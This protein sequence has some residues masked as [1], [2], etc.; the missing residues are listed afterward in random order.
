MLETGSAV[1][2]IYKFGLL[3]LAL[4]AVL[5]WIAVFSLRPQNFLRVNVLDV[6]QGDAIL[7]TTISGSQVLIDGGPAGGGVLR[8]LSGQMPFFDRSLDLVVA[9]HADADHI[10]GLV[11]VLARYRVKYVLTSDIPADTATFQAFSEK[12][13]ASGAHI[14]RP[15]PGMKIWLDNST[16]LEILGPPGNFVP[17]ESNETSIVTRLRYGRTAVML[18]GDAPVAEEAAMIVS[19]R[20]LGAD[21]LKVGHHGSKTSTSNEFLSAVAPGFV[22]ISVGVKN[23]YGHPADEVLERLAA[24]GVTI[25]RTDEEGALEYQSDGVSL[26]KK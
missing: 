2:K 18:S 9:T 25:D 15:G 7:A 10:G 22:A 14:I 19:G 11:E 23:R 21:L 1:K 5:V 13:A 26:G 4:L 8:E 6:G 12:L 24:H 3:V 16:L 17:V 20:P